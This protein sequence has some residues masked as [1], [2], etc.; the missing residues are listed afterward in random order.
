MSSWSPYNEAFRGAVKMSYV[1]LTPVFGGKKEAV[2]AFGL[3]VKKAYLAQKDAEEE[4]KEGQRVRA[5]IDW[6][7]LGYEP[8]IGRAHVFN[9]L[10]AVSAQGLVQILLL[11]TKSFLPQKIYFKHWI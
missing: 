5:P 6:K 3:P 9:I 7:T 2:V 1:R 8:E 10:N 11:P 4:Q